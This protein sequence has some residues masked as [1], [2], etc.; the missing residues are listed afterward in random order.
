[1]ATLEA[2]QNDLPASFERTQ[3]IA[4]FIKALSFAQYLAWIRSRRAAAG[5]RAARPRKLRRPLEC[6]SGSAREL[7]ANL[8]RSSGQRMSRHQHRESRSM[9]ERAGQRSRKAR[10]RIDA[11][12]RPHGHDLRV[13]RAVVRPVAAAARRQ[14]RVLAAVDKGRQRPE[15]EK[16]NQEDG[17]A[18]PHLK[19]MLADNDR[20]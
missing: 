2:R 7:N 8:R 1:M 20:H 4:L 12:A 10:R 14:A 15:S 3:T 16:Q 6:G 13:H 9:I 19:L 17:E 11:T 18:A 5:M